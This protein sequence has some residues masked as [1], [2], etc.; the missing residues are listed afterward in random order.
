MKRVICISSAS[1][2]LLSALLLASTASADEGKNTSNTEPEKMGS[3]EHGNSRQQKIQAP[4][5]E[6]VLA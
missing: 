5:R 4:H 1:A 6:S 3:S 2:I